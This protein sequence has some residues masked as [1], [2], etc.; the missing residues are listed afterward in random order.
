MSSTTIVLA[1][2][3]PIVRQGLRALLETEANL[4]IVGEASDGLAAMT[5]AERLESG[6]LVTDLM[7]PGMG[8]MEVVRQV[9]QHLPKTRVL[10]LS[11]Y[12]N[13]AYVLQALKNGAFGYVLKDSAAAELLSAVGE[14][15]MGRQYL[16]VGLSETS[17]EAYLQG[18]ASLPQTADD[19]LTP[20]EREVLQLA[21][22]GKSSAEVAGL[23]FISPRTAKTHRGRL[24]RKLGLRTQTELKHLAIW[25]G[26]LAPEL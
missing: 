20:R 19:T 1:D 25:R 14:V 6:I 10:I 8:G 22:E 11:M 16:S 13:E 5:L 23:L 3:H 12:S 18:T 9:H 7:M 4:S 26:I 24:M 15:A 21:A 2:D 17:V